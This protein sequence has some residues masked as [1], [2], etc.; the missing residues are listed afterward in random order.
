MK[1]LKMELNSREPQSMRRSITFLTSFVV[2]AAVLALSALGA[3]ISP[4]GSTNAAPLTTEETVSQEL[5]TYLQ[6]Q[7]QLHATQLAI[8][9][10]RKEAVEL[11]AQNN[12]T[13]STR[14]QAIEQSLSA[15][16]ARELETMQSSNRVLLIVAGAFACMGF[17]AMLLM[18]YFQWKTVSRLAELSAVMPG[19]ALQLPA[20][21]PLA[22]LGAGNTSTFSSVSTPLEQNN[23]ALLESI[24]RLEKRLHELEHPVAHEAT[25]PHEENGEAKAPGASP[26]G[27]APNGST[28]TAAA[29]DAAKVSVLLNKGQSLLNDEK[30]EEALACFDDVLTIDSNNAEAL[31]KKGTALEKLRK[32]NEAIEC[33]DRAIAADGTMTI[34]YLYKGGVFNRMERFSEALECYEQALRTQEKRRA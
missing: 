18:G 11:A 28:D 13:L 27:T 20:P 21:R 26:N 31:V 1:I 10:T 24:H 16:R 9:R 4:T 23:P 14:L 7:E 22:A 25:P 6:L 19:N 17:V 30:A 32:L 5:R 3:E 34:A 33:Y 8:E 15:Q 2:L 29:T 12:E